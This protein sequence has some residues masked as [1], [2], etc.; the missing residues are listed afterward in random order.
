MG[1]VVGW[2]REMLQ[3]MAEGCIWMVCSAGTDSDGD[4]CRNEAA[5]AST[6]QAKQHEQSVR[7]ARSDNEGA[8][9][10]LPRRATM[11]VGSEFVSEI[12]SSGGV[13]DDSRCSMAVDC[14]DGS[15]LCVFGDAYDITTISCTFHTSSRDDVD[16]VVVF[17]EC[18]Y[19]TAAG[20]ST[21]RSKL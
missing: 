14:D 15:V 2:K 7:V 20:D 6:I 18:N 17:V 13:D 1:V 19:S 9:S 8:I 3:R 10:E 11:V 12:G 21:S 4:D 5:M 16:F